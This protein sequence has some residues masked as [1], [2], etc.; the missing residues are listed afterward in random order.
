MEGSALTTNGTTSQE[1]FL[2]PSSPQKPSYT[3]HVGDRLDVIVASLTKRIGNGQRT[4]GERGAGWKRKGNGE[5]RY[6]VDHLFC[7]ERFAQNQ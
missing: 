2:V 4:M 6:E 1:G 3:D 7:E 5:G